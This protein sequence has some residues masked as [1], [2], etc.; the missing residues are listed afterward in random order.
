MLD[1]RPPPIKV[2]SQSSEARLIEF[3]QNVE[4]EADA[5]TGLC[6]NT[7]RLEQ[8]NKN[9]NQ[10]KIAINLIKDLCTDVEGVVYLFDDFAMYV[11]IKAATKSLIDKI[12]FQI[13]YLFMDDPLAYNAEGEENPEFVHF[14]NLEE[15]W[16]DFQDL[17]QRRLQSILKNR[18]NKQKGYREVLRDFDPKEDSKLL[19]ATRLGGVEKD[20]AHADISRVVRQQPVCVVN[21]K[22]EAN[23]IFS[24]MYINIAHLQGMLGLKVNL[25]SNKW[26]FKYLTEILDERMLAML[27]RSPSRYLDEPISLNL[28]VKTLLSSQFMEFDTM[29]KPAT[30]VSIVIEVQIADVYTDMTAFLAAKETAQS[31]GYRIC[32]DG[33]S[34]ST[35]SLI[36]RKYLGFDLVKLIWNSHVVD[37]INPENYKRILEAVNHCGKNRIILCRCDNEDAITFGKSLGITLFQG[38]YLDRQLNPNS[39]IEN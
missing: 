5:W 14:Y 31:L 21:E 22:G 9:N 7:Y 6:F 36:D 25:L 35:L 11:M 17:S 12:T 38:R 23:N 10:M 19:T 16:E 2:I 1:D 15:D 32:L 3:L 18:R 8:H 37:E 28:N 13:R 26:L 34:E 30:K 4:V 33:V 24:E 20:L 29:I 27:Q 39:N